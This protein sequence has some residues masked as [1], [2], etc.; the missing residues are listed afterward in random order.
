M[1]ILSLKLKLTMH[2]G[3]IKL[4]NSPIKAWHFSQ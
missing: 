2:F 4:V 3:L 1:H